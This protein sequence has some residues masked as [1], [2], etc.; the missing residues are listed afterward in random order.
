VTPPSSAT[1][2]PGAGHIPPERGAGFKRT[3]AMESPSARR[4]AARRC[5]AQV[6]AIS[7]ASALRA[8][9]L[10]R[11][12]PPRPA[13]FSQATCCSKSSRSSIHDA[14]TR[15][16]RDERVHVLDQRQ[17]ASA[18]LDGVNGKARHTECRQD[19]HSRPPD[20]FEVKV[21]H[22]RAGRVHA[23]G[24]LM[25][26]V[27]RP[28]P[29]SSTVRRGRFIGKGMIHPPQR[30][31]GPQSVQLQ[32]QFQA[33]TGLRSHSGRDRTFWLFGWGPLPRSAGPPRQ[34]TVPTPRC[35]TAISPGGQTSPRPLPL[36]NPFTRA[37]TGGLAATVPSNMFEPLRS[38]VQ[39]PGEESVPPRP[40][41]N[42]QRHQPR[43]PGD[44]SE[45]RS[46]APWTSKSTTSS[47]QSRSW[48]YS[49]RGTALSGQYHNWVA[50]RD[51]D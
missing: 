4:S 37:R 35:T 22:R 3:C 49:G 27:F 44:G 18:T 23:A 8:A 1:R 7:E 26:V 21:H 9:P 5:A 50:W 48:P 51:I 25:S 32:S 12:G 45:N 6:G 15:A 30:A 20:A 40:G 14:T 46:A 47:A 16:Q 17:G 2:L 10:P 33:P 31:S 36:Y 19:R 28:A 43:E 39:V 38:A 11:T 41:G 29:T 13:R 42:R 34:A 24:G